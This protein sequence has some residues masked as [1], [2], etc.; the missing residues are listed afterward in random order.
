M[1]IRQLQCDHCAARAAAG[2]VALEARAG[3][4]RQSDM[5]AQR[6]LQPIP[7]VKQIPATGGRDCPLPSNKPATVFAGGLTKGRSGC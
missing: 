5:N 2:P 1:Q 7:S 6:D 3:N 4:R